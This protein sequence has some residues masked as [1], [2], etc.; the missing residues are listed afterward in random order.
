MSSA[1]STRVF[2]KPPVPAPLRVLLLDD[3]CFDRAR[4]RRLCRQLGNPVIVHEVACI[5]AF[6]VLLEE[7][8]YDLLI[9]ELTLLD[10]SGFDAL[11]LLRQRAG[12]QSARV[13]LSSRH[14]QMSLAFRTGL[15]DGEVFVAKPALT[16]NQLRDIVRAK[17]FR[18]EAGDARPAP[19]RL[20]GSLHS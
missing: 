19:V 8:S 9:L 12:K 16:I 1:A 4:I 17:S 6:A 3:C 15:G 7:T 20:H 2:P 11:R 14:D 5:E 13:V 10:G 18:N